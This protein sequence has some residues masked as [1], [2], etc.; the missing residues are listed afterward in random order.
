MSHARAYSD[1]EF[2]KTGAGACDGKTLKGSGVNN[3]GVII[4]LFSRASYITSISYISQGLV[5]MQHIL[6]SDARIAYRRIGKLYQ[7]RNYAK[8]Y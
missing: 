1:N 3:K 4:N 2:L 8:Q 5:A 7:N 6:S